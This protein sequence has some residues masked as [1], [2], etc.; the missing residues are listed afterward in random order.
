MNSLKHFSLALLMLFSFSSC[1][2]EEILS[3]EKFPDEITLFISTHFPDNEIRQVVKDNDGF[4]RTYDV[5]LS[6]NIKLEFNRKKEIIDIESDS[7]LPDSV[8]P[9]KILQYVNENYPDD[10]ISSWELD[11]K[12]QKVELNGGL[13]LEFDKNGNFLRIDS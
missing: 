4:N 11:G 7:K 2:K 8:I 13:D 3:D 5:V 1:D 10:F 12:K 6:G 9:V